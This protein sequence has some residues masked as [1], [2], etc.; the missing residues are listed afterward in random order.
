MWFCTLHTLAHPCRKYVN[1][2]A[3]TQQTRLAWVADT[4]SCGISCYDGA[5]CCSSVSSADM[6]REM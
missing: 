6:R 2:E 3:T 5:P 4:V 1:V